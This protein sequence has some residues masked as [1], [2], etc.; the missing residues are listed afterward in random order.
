MWK[1][2][3]PAHPERVF[4]GNELVA[5]GQTPGGSGR[6]IIDAHHRPKV[7]THGLRGR[8]DRQPVIEPPALIRLEVAEADPLA[9]AR[10]R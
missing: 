5:V 9:G 6:E 2:R 1:M 4:P 10:D 7:A 3:R 8:G